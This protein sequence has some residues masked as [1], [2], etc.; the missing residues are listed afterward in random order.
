MY[1]KNVIALVLDFMYIDCLKKWRNYLLGGCVA[2]DCLQF[3]I[4]AIKYVDVFM[5][6][7]NRITDQ[8]THKM[9]ACVKIFVKSCVAF[10]LRFHNIP[11]EFDRFVS[12]SFFFISMILTW[13]CSSLRWHPFRNSFNR[14]KMMLTRCFIEIPHLTATSQIAHNKQRNDDATM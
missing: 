3:K 5:F 4:S 13:N 8:A 10:L 12:L 9:R 6:W 7:K 14:D 11:E 2:I 1:A